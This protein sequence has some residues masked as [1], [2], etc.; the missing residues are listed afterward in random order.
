MIKNK[1][2]YLVVVSNL[3]GEHPFP[4]RHTNSKELALKG[5]NYFKNQFPDYKVFIEDRP[6]EIKKIMRTK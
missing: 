3:N 4:A 1:K 5:L 6:E 2:Y